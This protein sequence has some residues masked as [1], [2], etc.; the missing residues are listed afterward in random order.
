[1]PINL[2]QVTTEI[3][4]DLDKVPRNLRAQVKRTVGEVII[5]EINSHLDRSTSPVS[6]G[7]YKRTKKD[8]SP[9]Q[10]LEEGDLRSNLESRNRAGNT[11]EIGI[12]NSK[13][14]PKAF[15]HNV[16]DTL[17]TRQFI[18]FEGE[19]FKRKI[20][21]R[22]N[23][24]IKSFEVDVDEPSREEIVENNV[25]VGDILDALKGFGL[26]GVDDGQG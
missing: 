5:D 25:T 7:D 19:N 6:G 16:G 15:N 21:S 8:G 3:E 4:L 11:I 23:E 17:P 26:V 13:Q 1:M 24:T 2:N 9:S 12:F 22:I 10:L 14:A 20:K 18:P